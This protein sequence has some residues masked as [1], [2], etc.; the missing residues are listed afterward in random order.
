M[1]LREFFSED[2][3]DLDLEAA[4]KDEALKEL[5]GVLDLDEKSEGILY[6][7]LKRREN[8][9]STGIGKGIAIPH[10]RSLVVNRLRVAFGRKPEGID[11]RA[12]DEQPVHNIFLIVAPPLEVSNQYLPVLGKIAQFSKEPEVA[13]RLAQI[14]T[15][16][17]FLALLEEKGI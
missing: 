17:E 3:V 13:T 12:I 10:C 6:K 11:F 5:I 2:V 1:E 8:L 7:M 16:R 15:P 9:G 14:Q 4:T